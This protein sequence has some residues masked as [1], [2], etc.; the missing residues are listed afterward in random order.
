MSRRVVVTGLGLVT[1]VGTD[2]ASTW[3][4]LLAGTPGAAEITKFDPQKLSV[5]FAC[6]VKGFDPLQYMDRKEARRYDLFAQFALA[7]ANQAVTQAGLEGHFPDPDRTGVVIGTGIGGMQTY[8]DNCMLYLTKGPDRVSPFFVPMFI[9]DIAA[10]LV[11]IRYG[12]KGPNFATVSACASSAHA[13]GESYNLIRQGIADAMVTGG[14]EAAITGLTVAAFANMKA[15]STRNDSPATASRPF[16]LDRDGFVLGDGGAVIVLESLDHAERRG[17]RILG[18]LLGYG[19]SGDAYHITAPAE[20]GEGA[21][22]AMRA[23]LE[24]GRI[25]PKDVGYINA[26]GTSTP[27]G[28][29]AETEAVKA[30]FGE[31]ARSLV[32]G[33][34]KSMTGHL[35]GAAGALEFGVSLL[36]ATCGVIPPTIN[37]FTPD[38]ECDLD[39]APNQ[40]VERRVDTALSNSFGFGGHNVT[41]AVRRWEA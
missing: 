18:E 36:V 9:P 30:V 4:G 32:F 39:S 17:A 31:H 25:D 24:D 11:S 13:I 12:L 26:H 27:Q 23:C 16:D 22:R 34:T 6:E 21:Q 19:L 14:A 1:P 20:H 8:E 10:G 33:S 3:N 5:R 7:A 37:Q 2:V 29:V 38:P 35:L 15:L 28:D 41:L 40:K